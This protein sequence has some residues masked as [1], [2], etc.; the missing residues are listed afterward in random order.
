MM[1]R[2]DRLALLTLS[3]ALAL[4]GVA[5]GI[6][7][8][9]DDV[10]SNGGDAGSGATGTTDGGAA[11]DP[12]GGG[13]AG[14]GP[15][16]GGSSTTTAAGGTTASGDEDC[17]DG[18]DNDGDGAIDCADSDCTPGFECV[19]AVPGGWTGY[20]HISR[21]D[22][23][24]LPP[25]CAGGDEPTLFHAGPA[26]PAECTACSCG[27]VSGAA[28]SPPA[29]SCYTNSTT[30]GSGEV[31]LTAALQDGQ[32]HKPANQ[33]GA[34]FALSCAITEPSQVLANGKCEPSAA[35]FPNKAPWQN[36][37]GACEQPTGGG[38]ESGQMCA[39]KASGN[40]GDGLCV[41]KEG[42]AACPA[43]AF[44][45]KVQVYK[46]GTDG[47][48]CAA[49]TCGDSATTCNG[50]AYT[51]FDSNNCDNQGNDPPIPVDSSTCK[52]V[53]ALLDVNSWSM[54]ATLPKPQGNCPP[55]GGEPQGAFSPTGPV[56]FCCQP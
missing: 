13:G 17:M 31:D 24:T 53:T 14:A 33:I 7:A 12:A 27:A 40:M 42:D 6:S 1:L 36:E 56:T 5:C 55:A 2:P 4:S 28:C 43:G 15:A 52:N 41:Q 10:F 47:R 48:S 44:S 21:T 50:G 9:V 35:D 26:G 51:V 11:G 39:P 23:P 34:A 25:P 54:Q 19:P 46:D 29:F 38:C 32:C 18:A 16:T 3:A 45:K 22:Y 37:V 30:C 20:F 8:S 49:C